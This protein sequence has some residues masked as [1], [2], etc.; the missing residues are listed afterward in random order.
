[1]SGLF[2]ALQSIVVS[3]FITG[4]LSPLLQHSRQYPQ[5]MESGEEQGALLDLAFLSCCRA[6]AKFSGCT[7]E[8]RRRVEGQDRSQWV[9]RQSSIP[10]QQKAVCSLFKETTNYQS[11]MLVYTGPFVS[12]RNGLQSV[13]NQRS[14]ELFL[15]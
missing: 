7:G 9:A 10:V 12:L 5:L 13:S 2:L 14:S 8:V 3:N 15:D 4:Y 1:M 11:K 6:A